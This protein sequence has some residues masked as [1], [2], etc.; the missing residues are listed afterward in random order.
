[1]ADTP[2]TGLPETSWLR[3]SRLTKNEPELHTDQIPRSPRPTRRPAIPNDAEKA[4]GSGM[5][6]DD[7]GGAPSG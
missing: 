4:R 1:M 5:T 2:V 6:P 7:D 3:N